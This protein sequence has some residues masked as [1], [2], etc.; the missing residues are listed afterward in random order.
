MILER[1]K[2][3][4]RLLADDSKMPNVAIM[5]ISTYHKNK[6]D[7]VNWYNP[8]FDYLDTDILYH[9]RIFNFTPEYEYYPINAKIIKGGTGF[10]IYSKL[11]DEI[12]NIVDLDYSLYP[13]CD[14]SILFLSRGCIRNCPFCVVRKK[15]GLIHR[16]KPTSLNTNGKYI[17]LMDN[18]FFACKEWKENIELL[19]SYDQPINFNT[20][21]DLRILNDEQCQALS[22]LKIKGIHCAWDNYEDKDIILPKIKLLTKY[23][24]PYKITTY[25]LVGFKNKEIIDEDIER[26][27]TLKELG[28]NPFAMGYINY[29]DKNYKK[30]QSV[31]DFC[32]WVNHKA[33]FKSCTFEEYRKE[34]KK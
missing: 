33:I 19:K 3:K 10:D 9:S 8:I 7:D 13:D 32:R 26:V 1:K 20:G 18:N 25:V 11:P 16:A 14:Y 15:E 6:G 29:N 4:V 17:E 22:E 21:I 30:S 24:K 5:K 2:M 31:K 23:I 27:L 34:R 12:E 28:V